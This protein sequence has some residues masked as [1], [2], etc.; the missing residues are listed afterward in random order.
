MTRL[1]PSTRLR[2]ST[3]ALYAEM[4]GQYP[5]LSPEELRRP[6]PAPKQLS[7]PEAAPKRAPLWGLLKRFGMGS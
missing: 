3:E 4:T 5:R 7:V 6:L 2:H 1:D